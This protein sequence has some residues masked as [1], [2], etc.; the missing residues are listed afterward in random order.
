MLFLVKNVTTVDSIFH[1]PQ[2]QAFKSCN[3]SLK[4]Y[5]RNYTRSDHQKV[6]ITLRFSDDDESYLPSFPNDPVHRPP[7]G[8]LSNIDRLSSY[9]ASADKIIMFESPVH[10]KDISIARPLLF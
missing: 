4:I 10:C 3:S 7:S 8:S 1:T 2:G 9:V 5:N 6:S